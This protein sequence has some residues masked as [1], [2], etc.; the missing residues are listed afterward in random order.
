[1]LS[2]YL[3]NFKKLKKLEDITA[4]QIATELS[5]E[6][7][8][9][10]SLWEW[11]PKKTL[12]AQYTESMDSVAANIA[13]GYGRFHKKDKIKFF[14]NARASTYEAAHW[15]KRAKIRGLLTET[16]FENILG[17]LRQLPKEIN[18]LIKVTSENLKH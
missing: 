6:V 5:D 12:G 7:W 11:F 18:Y 4:Y 16:Q 14:F 1:M 9:I 13:E 17:K 10:V 2:C 8:R 3:V 15:T